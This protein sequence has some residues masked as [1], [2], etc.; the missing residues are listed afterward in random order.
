MI[1]LLKNSDYRKVSNLIKNTNHELF[2]EAVITENVPGEIYVDNVTDPLSTLIITPISNVVAGNPNNPLFNA[3]IKE[4][5]NFYDTVI[6]DTE[7]WERK[8]H[9]IHCNVAIKKYRRSYYQ[10]DK[11]LFENFSENLEEQYTLEYVYSDKLDELQYENSEEIKDWFVFNNMDD[12]DDYCL[13]VYIR[14]GNKIVCWCLVDC[15]VGDRI[16]IGINTDKDF[17]R[18]GL[19]TITLAATVNASMNKGVKEIGWHCVDT[20][21]GSITIAER[22]GFKKLKEYSCF[23]PYPPIEN[24]TDL[25]NEQWSD[26]ALHYEEMNKMEP[27][28]YGQAAR[29]WGLSNNIDKAM[30]NIKYLAETE[31]NSFNDNLLSFEGFA[32]FQE[33]EEWKTFIKTLRENTER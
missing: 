21:V 33:M 20:N 11:L 10:F 1:N 5:L 7:E 19:G 6:C 32:S 18:R 2:I 9:E 4:K 14:K 22:V 23:T 16:E 25:N 24:V 8:I 15:I 28:Y 31:P 13:G 27:K 12:V 29:C 3:E 17:R 26:W 30:L